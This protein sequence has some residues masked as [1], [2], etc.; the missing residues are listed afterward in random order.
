L[1]EASGRHGQEKGTLWAQLDYP[2]QWA[3][4]GRIEGWAEAMGTRLHR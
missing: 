1:E 3:N 2:R 4:G